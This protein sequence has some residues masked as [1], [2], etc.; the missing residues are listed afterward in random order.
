MHGATQYNTFRQ[1]FESC[2]YREHETTMIK[3]GSRPAIIA[4]LDSQVFDYAS[5]IRDA[6]PS[7]VAH[8]RSLLRG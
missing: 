6:K 8:G 5:F 3:N 4:V 7:L 1:R 2:H